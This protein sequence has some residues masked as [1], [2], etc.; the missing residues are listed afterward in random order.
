MTQPKALHK[1][2]SGAP[3]ERI[4]LHP[5]AMPMVEVLVTSFGSDTAQ[6]A[7]RGAVLVE[8]QLADGTDASG[9]VE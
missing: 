8:T 9:S 5:I 7:L 4:T 3:I 6:D 1:V 2:Q